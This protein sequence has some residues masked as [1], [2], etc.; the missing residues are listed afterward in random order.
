MWALLLGGALCAGWIDAVVGG[1]GL[2]LIPLLLIVFPELAPAKALASNKLAAIWGTATAAVLFVRRNGIS[3]RLAATGFGMGAL[4]ASIG[5]SLASAISADVMRPVVIVLMIAVGVFIC[6]KPAFGRTIDAPAV[7]PDRRQLMI[8]LGLV[9][10]IGFYDGI[11]G[12]G[13]GMFLILSL[14]GVLATDFL[15]SAT[16]AKVVNTATNLGALT[17]FALQGNVLWLL[18]LTLAVANV[19]GSVIGSK[20]TL[21]AGSGFVRYALLAVVVVMSVKLLIDQ[22]G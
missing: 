11:F 8:A 6:A 7:R 20:M 14:S 10:V 3:P 18:G 1:G 13:T 15:S 19:V 5:A 22:F 9:C 2:V 16:V 12:P 21:K 17:V 4:G